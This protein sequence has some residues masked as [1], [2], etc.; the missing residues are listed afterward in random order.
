MGFEVTTK[1]HGDNTNGVYLSKVLEGAP[2]AEA[3]LREG[4]RLISIGGRSIGDVFDVPGAF[5]FIRANQFTPVEV[6]RDNELLEVSVKTLPRP[7][8]EPLI[9][10]EE[11]IENVSE[12]P[13]AV[14][15][16]GP[17]AAPA[18]ASATEE[19]D[20]EESVEAV[21]AAP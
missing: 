17:P 12:L 8:N 9:K 11:S 5:F 20:R 15:L 6:L 10:I 21:E 2:A 16:D 3:G 18:E 14:Q 7:E 4:D 13:P 19:L 1:L